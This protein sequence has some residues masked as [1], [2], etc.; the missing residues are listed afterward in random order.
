MPAIAKMTCSNCGAEISTMN[1]S[2]GRKYWLFTIPL[3]LLGF[4]PLIKMTFFKGDVVKDLKITEVTKR[5]AGSGLEVLGLITNEGKHK[6][7]SVVVEAEFFDASGAFLD[8]WT[9]TLRSDIAPGAQEHFKVTLRN[10]DLK[11]QT[12]D[13][14]M[15]V[16]IAGGYSAPF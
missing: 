4:L 11:D 6:W 3:M 13:V 1:M 9:E 7:S 15:V 12:G 10:A 2:W 16:K 8:E 5:Q 14:K